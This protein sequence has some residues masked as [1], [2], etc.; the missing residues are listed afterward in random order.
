MYIYVII[1][2]SV[3]LHESSCFIKDEL[4]EKPD[5]NM[6]DLNFRLAN[7]RNF[8]RFANSTKTQSFP[9]VLL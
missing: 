8:R 9:F 3:F 7:T 1:N 4:V 6:S 2:G 5:G